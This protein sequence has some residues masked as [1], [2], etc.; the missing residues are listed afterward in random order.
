MIDEA[1]L[2][3]LIKKSA[4]KYVVCK[5]ILNSFD[6]Y[7]FLHH[8]ET[9]KIIW[10]VR[11]YKD[12]IASSKKKFGMN[13][14]RLLLDTLNDRKSRNWIA[15]GIHDSSYNAL[16]RIT[17]EHLHHNDYLGLI[18]YCVNYTIF[19]ENL[20]DH[21]RVKIMQYEHL[22]QDVEAKLKDL[23]RFIGLPEKRTGLKVYTQSIKK[24]KDILLSPQV[25]ELCQSLY[26]RIA[27]L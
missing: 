17:S 14:K 18:W 12:V 1:K 9:S 20:A 11:H 10:M 6:A 15:Y 7:K 16:K 19:E 5:P 8:Y 23:Y 26:T 22:V 25:E 3:S 4:S 24:G 2:D 13:T 27:S 21:H